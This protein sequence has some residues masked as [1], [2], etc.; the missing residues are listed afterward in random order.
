MCARSRAVRYKCTFRVIESF[1]LSCA[2]RS[3][4]RKSCVL[5]S[6]P[7]ACAACTV[8]IPLVRGTVKKVRAAGHSMMGRT[9]LSIARPSY[10]PFAQQLL[11]HENPQRGSARDRGPAVGGPGERATRPPLYCTVIWPLQRRLFLCR[12]LRRKGFALVEMR[13]FTTSK[14]PSTNSTGDDYIHGVDRSL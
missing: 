5:T 4:I 2:R 6:L 1:S 11:S 14:E 13:N 10:D 9:S 12:R 3:T 8:D 7:V